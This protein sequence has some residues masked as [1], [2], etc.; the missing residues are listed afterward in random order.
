MNKIRQMAL[1]IVSELLKQSKQNI[2]NM[3]QKNSIL[4]SII[5]NNKGIN[6][7]IDKIKQIIV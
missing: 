7:M 5:Q 4:S 1:D 3:S 6:R 2:V